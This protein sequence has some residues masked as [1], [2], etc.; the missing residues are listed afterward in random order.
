MEANFKIIV[1]HTTN[2]GNA[3]SSCNCDIFLLFSI[4]FAFE[5]YNL[6]TYVR[7]YLL[8]FE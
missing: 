5:R 7:F 2:A 4:D 6:I 1:F 3:L 8:A